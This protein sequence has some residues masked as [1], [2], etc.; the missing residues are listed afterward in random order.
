MGTKI[1][2]LNELSNILM[3]KE[4][5]DEGGLVFSKQF[6]IGQLLKPFSAIKQQGISLRLVEDLNVCN[7]IP[8]GMLRSVEKTLPQFSVHPAKDAS[9]RDV[10]P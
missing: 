8:S 3:N 2:I 9:L 7:C 4:K 10:A 6:K 1:G 5:R